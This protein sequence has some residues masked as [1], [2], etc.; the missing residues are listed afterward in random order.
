V[1][2]SLSGGVDSMVMLS[3]LKYKG[4]DVEAI[5]IIY[6]NRAE[7]EDEYNFLV[8]FCNLIGVKLYVYRIQWLRRGE[9]DREFYEDMTRI[10]RFSVYRQCSYDDE[11]CVLLGH[12]QDDI[13]ENIWTNIAHCQHLENLKKMESEEVQHGVRIIR[14]FLNIPK[15]QIYNISHSASIPYLKNT[16]PSWSNRGKF[17]EYF[18]AATVEQF[19]ENVDGKI[20]EF[21]TAIQKQNYL[22]QKLLYEPIYN[23]F[24][25]NQINVTKAIE[26]E[27]DA[28]SWLMIFENICHKKLS[29]ARP[30]IKCI[31][32][33]HKRLGGKWET[34]NVEMGKHLKIKVSKCDQ[35]YCMQF[36]LS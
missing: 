29:V 26:A 10:L 21:A 30:S 13:V 3:L 27:L 5:H 1:F 36:I 32:D 23:S 15:Y 34:L 2:V 22:L 16:T 11:P 28:N 19:G 4:A 17:R 18:H 20:I 24:I 12:I 7:S 8:E 6:G 35:E 33:F 25:N 9:I 31:Q 14:P